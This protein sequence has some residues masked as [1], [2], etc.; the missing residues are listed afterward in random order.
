MTRN[1]RGRW[2]VAAMAGVN[3]VALWS[4]T[5]LAQVP[6][7]DTQREG[8]ESS[9]AKC[10]ARSQQLKTQQLSPQK[11]VTGSVK[12]GGQG[13]GQMASNTMTGQGYAP[14]VGGGAQVAPS[15]VTSLPSFTNLP[16]TGSFG[17]ASALIGSLASSGNSGG[18]LGLGLSLLGAVGASLNGG[19]SA[20]G[21]NSS[22][23]QGLG[24][25]IGS[26]NGTQNGWD[27]NSQARVTSGQVWNQAVGLSSVTT[28]LWNQRLLDQLAGSSSIASLLSYDPAKAVFVPSASGSPAPS[29]AVTTPIVT[30]PASNTSQSLGAA[31]AGPKQAPPACVDSAGSPSLVS[32]AD[33]AAALAA[34]KSGQATQYQLSGSGQ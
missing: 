24:G 22:Q 14:L 20:I 17:S 32:C 3:L 29:K 34:A 10:V 7:Q 23:F 28:Q 12:S 26:A 6:V 30:P 8:K 21:Q 9:I 25:Q 13:L 1:L 31:Q 16:A 11:G 4:A 18:M 27:Q 5:A 19:Q 2:S 33:M 15:A